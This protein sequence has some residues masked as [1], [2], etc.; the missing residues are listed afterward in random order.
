MD[1]NFEEY[2][3]RREQ[4]IIEYQ[5]RKPKV[6]K[7]VKENCTNTTTGYH[8]CFSCYT[9]WEKSK[10]KNESEP[11]KSLFNFPLK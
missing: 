5:S 9:K 4:A 10:T 3:K 2:S 8:W 6:K 7:C 11:E 1:F